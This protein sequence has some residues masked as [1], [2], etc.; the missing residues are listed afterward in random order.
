MGHKMDR[1]KAFN[2]I[3]LIVYAVIVANGIFI[4]Y[5]NS[6]HTLCER[7]QN[8]CMACGMR[9]AISRLLMLD[10]YGAYKSNHGIIVI[11]FF[12]CVM[13]IDIGVMIK[14]TFL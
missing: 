13:I 8:S 1:R 11:I 9:Q 6:F 14:N 12:A 10:F 2:E 5:F 7:G 4:Q 3:R